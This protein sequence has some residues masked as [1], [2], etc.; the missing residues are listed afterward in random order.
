MSKQS[1][2]ASERRSFLTRFNTGAASVAA[3][4]FGRVA[5]AQVKSEV[6]S[7]PASRWEPARH[8]KDDW[9]DALPGKHRLVIDTTSPEGF[10]NAL[11]YGSNFMLTNRNDYGLQNQDLAVIVVARH[12]STGYGFNNDM[13]AKYGASLSGETPSANAQASANAK[14]PPKANPSASSLASLSTQGVQFGVC[15]MATRRLAGMIA[16][17][18]GGD[19]DAVFAEMTANLVSNARMVPA[20]IVA[21]SRAQE[22]GYSLVSA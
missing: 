13:W 11:L 4:V 12:V 15:S 14:E 10:R 3:L 5:M 16:R 21:V 20:G 1:L 19:T 22:R 17:A 8:D 18:A 9:M 7:A 2:L 6:K